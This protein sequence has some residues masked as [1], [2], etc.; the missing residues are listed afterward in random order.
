M[1]KEI[2]TYKLFRLKNGQLYPLYVDANTP[3]PIGVWLSAKE[4]PRTDSGKVKSKL[5]ELAFRPGWHSSDYPVALHIGESDDGS[6]KPKYRP[7][8]Q[9]WVECLIHDNVD[10]QSIADSQGNS[11]KSKYVKEIPINGN[12]KYRTNPNMYGYWYISGE[13][14]LLR[15]LTDEEVKEINSETG[16]QDLPRK[17]EVMNESRKR[18]NENFE[19]VKPQIQEAIDKYIAKYGNSFEIYVDYRDELDKSTIK[20]IFESDRPLDAFYE[21]IGDWDWFENAN[22][23]YDYIINEQL[24]LP[25]EI[26]EDYR[27]EIFDMLSEQIAYEIPYDHFDETVGFDVFM[28]DPESANREYYDMIVFEETDE[29]DEYGNYKKQLTEINSMLTKFLAT[30]GYTAE[31]FIDYVN[32]KKS[33]DKF[34]E[35]LVQ[36]ILDSDYGDGRG[37]Q[38]TFLVQ[39]PITEMAKVI[40]E[41]GK[42]VIPKDAE[43][44]LVETFNGSGGT[45]GIV[46]KNNIEGSLKEKGKPSYQADGDFEVYY[47]DGYHYNVD[48]IYGLVPSVWNTDVIFPTS[49]SKVIDAYGM[50]TIKETKSINEFYDVSDMDTVEMEIIDF[51]YD[52]NDGHRFELDGI[53]FYLGDDEELE[54][55]VDV[56]IEEEFMPEWEEQGVESYNVDSVYFDEETGRGTAYIGLFKDDI[57][58]SRRRNEDFKDAEYKH[59]YRLNPKRQVLAMAKACGLN[60]KLSDIIML[61]MSG[62]EK[63]I[64]YG[65]TY[66]GTV[67][68][69]L[70]QDAST[71]AEYQIRKDYNDK[72]TL[73]L[74][75]EGNKVGYYMSKTPY[76]TYGYFS[77]D[78]KKVKDSMEHNRDWGGSQ[79]LYHVMVN[80]AELTG[81]FGKDSRYIAKLINDGEG[82]EV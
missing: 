63:S 37:C 54:N 62:G 56:C 42:I 75:S 25:D 51:G 3:V 26:K 29:Q 50:E 5:G 31:Q 4:G 19:E 2:K 7:A 66:Y 68:S 64:D 48:E 6:H 76:E 79:K 10:W 77:R 9:V 60:I 49:E 55:A 70:F 40:Q 58:E 22:Y 65:K 24:D 81:D 32:N 78:Y 53:E 74:F 33:D 27:S 35:S 69:A 59:D 1:N 73:T 13:I 80:P 36:E 18:R 14:K 34:L 23:E 57:N 17:E 45:L 67:Y 44:G 52:K 61:E 47:K 28:H 30:Q 8:N 16:V 15:I 71:G 39:A 11:P 82:S 20:E 72:V 43:C 21:I 38:V 12:Y 41:G 46:L